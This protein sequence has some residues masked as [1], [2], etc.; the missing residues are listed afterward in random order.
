MP[1]GY[2]LLS[3]D[4]R[5]EWRCPRT[6]CRAATW[7]DAVLRPSAGWPAHP[8]L[9]DES[10]GHRTAGGPA[11]RRENRG[12]QWST[13]MRNGA[14]SPSPSSAQGRGLACLHLTDGRIGRDIEHGDREA[15]RSAPTTNNGDDIQLSAPA[16]GDPAV[17]P[18][19][20]A[21]SF[22][23]SAPATRT[24]ER[25]PIDMA[26]TDEPIDAA[27]AHRMPDWQPSR[28]PLSSFP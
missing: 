27:R 3:R 10:I 6:T 18:K 25:G 21:V 16:H 2:G 28:A 22:E 12:S 8:E 13:T 17:G 23:A 15:R 1:G 20:S 9:L 5:W 24:Q 14:A 19:P 4:H 11:A 26:W 7:A